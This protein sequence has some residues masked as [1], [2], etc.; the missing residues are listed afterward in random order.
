MALNFFDRGPLEQDTGVLAPR[1]LQEGSDAKT[2]QKSNT[3]TVLTVTSG[4]KL[5]VSTISYYNTAA[6]TVTVR[7][8]GASGT[9][10]HTH[11]APVSNVLYSISPTTP[12]VFETDVYLASSNGYVVITGWEE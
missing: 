7:D 12:F 10:I 3:G 5:Y 9:I 11:S 8:G 6:N 4:K 1:Y 2:A